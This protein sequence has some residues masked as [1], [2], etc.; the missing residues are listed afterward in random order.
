ML[1]F[2]DSADI[3]EIKRLYSCFPFD[4][5]TTNP[6]ILSSTKRDF[7]RVLH[8]IRD[9]LTPE[10]NL[11]V[12]TVAPDAP[13]MIRDAERIIKE[14]GENTYIKIPAVKE[15]YK[16]MDYLKKEGRRVCSTA[17]YSLSQAFLSCKLS[18]DYI[19]PYVN[20]IDNQSISG[21]ETVKKMEDIIENNGF[22]TKILA[23]SFKNVFQPI[24]LISYG[25]GALTLPPSIIDAL[26]DNREAEGALLSFT[27]DFE[28]VYGKNV[29]MEG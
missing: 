26:F 1:L 29:T 16:A 13:G 17:V 28:S 10:G 12:Q 11:F 5:V 3:E 24:D 2:I 9:F 25:V 14:L 19:A 22:E 8:E 6:T 15:G 20:R 27:H 7:Y 4:G 23:A 21:I 18:V